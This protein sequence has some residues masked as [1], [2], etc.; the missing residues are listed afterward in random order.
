MLYYYAANVLDAFLF[1]GS[2]KHQISKVFQVISIVL[3][4]HGLCFFLFLCGYKTYFLIVK[5][6]A[7]WK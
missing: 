6:L 2:L 1:S 4:Q 7:F 3:N 5:T